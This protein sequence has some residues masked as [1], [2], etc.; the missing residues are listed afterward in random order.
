MRQW[1]FLPG[2]CTASAL[3]TVTHDWLQLLND[4]C[5]VFFDLKKAFDSVPHRLLLCRLEEISTDPC[6]VQWIRSYLTRRLQ[7][8]VIGGEQSSS[9]PVISRVPQGSVLGPLLFLVFINEIASQISIGSQ[10]SLFA[11]DIALYRSILT[12][13]DYCILQSDMSLQ[14][15]HGSTAPCFPCNLQN[16]ALFSSPGK[17]IP[18]SLPLALRLYSSHSGLIC[19]I[20]RATDPL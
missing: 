3:L 20:S 4:V 12:D 10:I 16:A 7:I 6:I 18:N 17:G 5:S 9:L 13:A 15:C 2:R 1:G 8:V 11:D 19:Q 14:L